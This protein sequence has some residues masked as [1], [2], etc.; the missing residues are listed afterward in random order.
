M[1]V[2]LL[3]S[4]MATFGTGLMMGFRAAIMSLARASESPRQAADRRALGRAHS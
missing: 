2:I 1:S 3:S 4:A